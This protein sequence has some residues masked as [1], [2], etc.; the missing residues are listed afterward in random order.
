[1]Q[2]RLLRVNGQ[3][4][5]TL[6]SQRPIH[7]KLP[8]LYRY[9][10]TEYI[11]SFFGSG[12]L[13]LSSFKKFR[14]YPDEIRGDKAE[15]GGAISAKGETDDR[16]VLITKTGEDC[17]MLSASLSCSDQLKTEFKDTEKPADVFSITDP[18]NFA[19][20]VMN[21][22]PGC[23]ETFVGYCNYQDGRLV[24]KEIRGLSSKDFRGEDGGFMIGHPQMAKRFSQI[25]GNGV[26]LLFLKDR[27]HQ[28][29]T[30]FRFVWRMDK[31]FFAI[32]SFID[33]TCKEAVQHCSRVLPASNVADAML[34]KP[35][36]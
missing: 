14:E 13:R 3:I 35:Q 34:G 32:E 2:Q 33:L 11:D 36:N 25:L 23:I 26:D 15:G 22:L 1:V 30:E 27:F 18:I 29:Q 20:A 19:G 28:N 4:V 12:A 7:V 16:F 24:E 5:I 6:T 8:Q 10:A 9:S 21:A 31:R 17:Y